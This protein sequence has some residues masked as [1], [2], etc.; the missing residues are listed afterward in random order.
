MEDERQAGKEVAGDDDFRYAS[1]PKQDMIGTKGQ[2]NDKGEYTKGEEEDDLSY[3]GE[4]ND[5]K[6][7]DKQVEAAREDQSGVSEEAEWDDSALKNAA[8]EIREIQ[9]KGQEERKDGKDL[10]VES[11]KKSQLGAQKDDK[12]AKLEDQRND[13]TG[14]ALRKNPYIQSSQKKED[15]DKKAQEVSL[16][17]D[18]GKATPIKS[19]K[20]NGRQTKGKGQA[21]IDD[22][23]EVDSGEA[24]VAMF[25]QSNIKT[26]QTQTSTR[27]DL[28]QAM[29]GIQL[30]VFR[31]ML[32]RKY[33][34]RYNL[35]LQV[36]AS[37]DPVAA[38]IQAAKAF[39]AQMVETDKTAALVPWAEEHQQ[40][41]PLLLSLTRFPTTL[42]ALKK[43]FSWAQPN[44]KGQMLYVS[45]LMVH[46][47]PYDEIMENIRWWLSERKFGLWKWQVQLETVKPIGYLL[48]STRML[49]PEYM[50]QVVEEAANQHKKACKFGQKLELGFQW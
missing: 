12:G 41:N 39:W 48:Y 23:T 26:S 25:W 38:L 6:E 31:G 3:L 36:P 19:N 11:D 4:E 8:K 28:R 35:K 29:E 2:L 1:L 30:P 34:F 9:R 10:T 15:K 7:R 22:K 37:E 40:E 44:T 33:L 5:E 17:N 47:I 13:D 27:R 14:K 16:R 45:I 43:Y 32:P 18:D 50:K 46:N 21:P 20:T 24:S 49:E 42:G